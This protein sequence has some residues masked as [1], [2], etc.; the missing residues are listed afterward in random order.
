MAA[1]AAGLLLGFRAPGLTVA[2][3]DLAT[4]DASPLASASPCA[5]VG[6]AAS[7]APGASPLAGASGTSPAPCTT[8]VASPSPS[9]V[10][11]VE[12]VLTGQ[13]VPTRFGNIQVQITVVGTQ[14]TDVQ[15]LQLPYD[16]QYS[17]EI[18]DYVAPYLRQMALQAQSAQIDL[19]S[20]AT[21]TS[22]G[23]AVSLQSAID[24]IA[25]AQP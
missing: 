22:Q 8:D 23:Y 3:T 12:Q 1:G 21:Y 15:A 19:I 18:S 24:Q 6:V 4:A 2:A 16:R 14:I 13:V 25:T 9:A 7:A 20:G 5:V 10:A 17:A 11:A